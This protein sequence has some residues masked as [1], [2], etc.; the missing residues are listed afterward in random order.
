MAG[1]WARVGSGPEG[2]LTDWGGQSSRRVGSGLCAAVEPPPG[3]RKEAD[4][5]RPQRG[6]FWA[7]K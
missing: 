6:S 1:E 2:A 7:Q 4:G 3:P 5:Q